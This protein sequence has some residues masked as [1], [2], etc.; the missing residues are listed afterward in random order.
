MA[1]N[2]IGLKKK[3]EEMG[4]KKCVCG[5]YEQPVC[6][7]TIEKYGHYIKGKV[8]YVF[9]TQEPWAEAALLAAGARYITTVEYM[10]IKTNHPK[11]TGVHPGEISK[12][13]LARGKAF[14]ELAD[15]GFAFS[16]YEHDGLGRY[17]DPLNPF[18][19]LESIARVHCLLKPDGIFFLG[20]PVG[21]DS[22]YWNA[23]RFYGKLRLYLAFSNWEVIDVIGAANR[24]TDGSREGDWHNQPMFVLRKKSLKTSTA[25]GGLRHPKV[26]VVGQQ[27]AAK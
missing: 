10:K 15:F 3:I 1:V 6:A 18:A 24:I 27:D 5:V 25:H 2:I 9:G 14:G 12:N 20:L 7:E 11:L 19:D 4:Q 23:H 8:G 16:S 26:N 21:V 13:F 22:V 17:G